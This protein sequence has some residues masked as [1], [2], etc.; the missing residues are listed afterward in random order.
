MSKMWCILVFWLLLM[1]FFT[2]CNHKILIWKSFN[3]KIYCLKFFPLVVTLFVHF[4]GFIM[5]GLTFVR[6][7]ALLWLICYVLER[8]SVNKDKLVSWM[9][10]WTDIEMRLN[11]PNTCFFCPNVTTDI[12]AVFSKQ[13]VMWLL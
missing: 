13:E 8:G 12:R 1:L 4:G 7:E 2:T 5:I 11:K 3:I 6:F 9:K 10:L